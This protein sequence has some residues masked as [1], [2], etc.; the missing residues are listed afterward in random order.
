RRYAVRLLGNQPDRERVARSVS[1]LNML[2]KDLPPIIT[3]HGD[4]DPTVPYQHAVRLHG[5]LDE[6]KI[7][8]KLVTVPGGMHGGFPVS[9]MVRAHTEIR[10]FL[11]RYV[12]NR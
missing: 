2:R 5:A 6:F 4:Q 12:I 9:E 8:N 10:E 3:I 11:T 1:P 7:P